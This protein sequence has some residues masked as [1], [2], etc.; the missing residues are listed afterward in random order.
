[1]NTRIVSLIVTYTRDLGIPFFYNTSTNILVLQL[2]IY[3]NF[4]EIIILIF[5]R[6]IILVLIRS[7]I[8]RLL[9]RYTSLVILAR[10]SLL[11]LSIPRKNISSITYSYN[12]TLPLIPL[13]SRGFN[14]IRRGISRRLL[15]SQFRLINI[16]EYPI[17]IYTLQ[18]L[19]L[20]ENLNIIVIKY[21]FRNPKLVLILAFKFTKDSITRIILKAKMI[22]NFFTIASLSSISSVLDSIVGQFLVTFRIPGHL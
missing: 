18:D 14:I 6:T 20:A 7:F 13:I 5:S 11:D 10:I 3:P 4:L 22:S 17:S 15:N 9:V 21:Q 2:L 12:Y 16:I 1:M 8:A 19:L